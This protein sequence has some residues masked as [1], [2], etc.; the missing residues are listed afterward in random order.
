MWTVPSTPSG[1]RNEGYKQ[2]LRDL[3]ATVHALWAESNEVF[4]L[5]RDKD[6]NYQDPRTDYTLGRREAVEALMRELHELTK[7]S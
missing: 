2:G 4:M 3:H 1:S 6:S 5:F 7:R